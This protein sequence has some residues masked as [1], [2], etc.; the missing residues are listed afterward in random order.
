MRSRSWLIAL[1]AFLL[2]LGGSGALAQIASINIP[3]GS[4]ADVD[5][6][7]ITKETDAA[8]QKA[9][10][11]EFVTKYASDP[12]AVAYGNAQLAQLAVSAGDA[13]QAME[14]GDKALA[15]APNYLDVLVLEVESAQKLGLTGKIMD[16]AARGGKA[17]NGIDGE[18]KPAGVSDDQFA[19]DKEQKKSAAKP[20]YDFLE[21]SAYAAFA[22]EK[23]PKQRMAYI[24]LFNESF[25]DSKYEGQASQFA[26]IT[27][28]ELGDPAGA[29]AY[30]ETVLAQ[31]PDDLPVLVVMAGIYAEEKGDA[32]LA[33]AVNYAQHAIAVAKPDAPDADEARKL[34]AAI[35]E[36]SLGRALMRQNK[37]P[38]AVSA[39]QKAAPELKQNP[40]AYSTVLYYLA[41]AYSLQREYAQAK[42][43]LNEAV[44]V[45]GPYQQQAR[46]LLVKVNAALAKGGR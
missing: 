38:A 28:Q 35:A 26:I 37:M 8:K 32:N 22:R 19:A 5:L 6:Q 7:A 13:K 40:Q 29:I 16:Y 3:A 27:L 34:A 18:P 9:M 46:A 15:A 33:K 25:P 2:A 41:N 42:Q 43:V 23:D 4:P 11:T 17:V 44:A 31:K 36:S 39:L 14:Y 24:Q 45:E 10:Y 20:A 21:G 12:M 1:L 30:G